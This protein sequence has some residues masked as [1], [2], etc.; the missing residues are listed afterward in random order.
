MET[1]S[2]VPGLPAGWPSGETAEL[3]A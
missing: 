1:W 2:I 3:L